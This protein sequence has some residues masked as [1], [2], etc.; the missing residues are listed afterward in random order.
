MD[1]V[2]SHLMMAVREEVEL[3]RGYIRELHEKNKELERENQLL[4]KLVHTTD[5]QNTHKHLSK[6]EGPA[7]SG[8]T[9]KRRTLSSEIGLSNKAN[10]TKVVV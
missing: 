5:C 9:S 4:K 3:L 7:S 1:L 6:Q 8:P 2:K 10:R